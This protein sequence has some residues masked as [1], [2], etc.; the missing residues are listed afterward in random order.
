VELAEFGRPALTVGGVEVSPGLSKSFELLAYLANGEREE[1]S[2]ERLLDALFDGRREA[3]TTAYLRQASLKLRKAV[4]D[5]LDPSS[6]PGTVRLS[7]SVRVTTESRR[8]ISLLGE[9]AAT[10]GEERL[11][12]LLAALEIADRGPY[13][14]SVSSVWAEDRRQRL[15]ELVRSARLEAAEVALAVGQLAQARRLAEAVV[16]ADPYREAAWR[17]LMR[18][19]AAL[20]D[21]DRVIAAYRSCVAALHEIG[22]QPSGATV[23]LLRDFRR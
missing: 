21:Q 19:A 13:L 15:E 12:L 16:T 20:G 14:S 10:R 9:A 17:L 3:S 11:A 2:R 6:R 1:V 8:L 22:A 7:S 4:P 18:L 5:V 23:A